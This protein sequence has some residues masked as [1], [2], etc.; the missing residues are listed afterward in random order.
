VNQIAAQCLIKTYC[1]EVTDRADLPTA[2]SRIDVRVANKLRQLYDLPAASMPSESAALKRVPQGFA[3]LG[4]LPE[5]LQA[6][7]RTDR[8]AAF[9][10]NYA[11]DDLKNCVSELKRQSEPGRSALLFKK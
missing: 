1:P 4:P 6:L 11:R 8:V 9:L 5:Y 3:H 2:L 7:P 10:L